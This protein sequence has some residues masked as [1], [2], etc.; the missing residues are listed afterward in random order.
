MIFDLVKRNLSENQLIHDSSALNKKIEKFIRTTKYD[1]TIVFIAKYAFKKKK[2]R[3]LK[4]STRF[5]SN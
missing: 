2:K 1:H 4:P 5:D 3:S